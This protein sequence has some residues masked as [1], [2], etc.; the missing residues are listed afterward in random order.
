MSVSGPSFAQLSYGS[1][2]LP[3]LGF[4]YLATQARGS[5]YQQLPSIELF[6]TTAGA[7][8]YFMILA[9]FAFLGA[10]QA[11]GLS[12]S[13]YGRE[14][15][16]SRPKHKTVQLRH[17]FAIMLN[18]D[19]R[20]LPAI[21]FRI[22]IRGF[23]LELL[24]YL[25]Y[26]IRSAMYV[27][28]EERTGPVPKVLE[29]KPLPTHRLEIG[30]KE[31]KSLTRLV[32]WRPLR[33]AGFL[34]LA[35]NSLMAKISMTFLLVYL[36]A[37]PADYIAMLL[38]VSHLVLLYRGLVWDYFPRVLYPE[39]LRNRFTPEYELREDPEEEGWPDRREEIRAAASSPSIRYRERTEEE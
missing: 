23:S 22:A 33:V 14:G 30:Y 25:V 34:P 27:P 5:V 39:A 1:Y 13:I 15:P 3:A 31:L 35:M 29:R 10:L 32:L 6:G 28:E 9:I 17:H 19:V 38:I 26:R 16:A 20:E 4:G 18:V 36:V 7:F 2:Y 24:D 37:N 21:P 8:H 11:H 12:I